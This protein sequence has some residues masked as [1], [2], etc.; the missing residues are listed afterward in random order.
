ML[1]DAFASEWTNSLDRWATDGGDAR[2][3]LDGAFCPGLH[4]SI[5]ACLRPE[6]SVAFLFESLPSCDDESRD[7]SPFVFS[8]EPDNLRLARQLER[9]N[10]WPMVHC[11]R[12]TEATASLAARLGDWCA[13]DAD[14]Q[15]LNL[16][17]P[18]TR[19]LSGICALLTDRQR[20]DM[21]GPARR[22]SYIGR[23]GRWADLDININCT[24]PGHVEAT[25]NRFGGPQLDSAQFAAM[26]D[27]GEADALMFVL[28]ERG[29]N[30]LGRHAQVY[31][32]VGRALELARQARLD[33]AST[34]EWCEA[35][36]QQP[37]WI[38]DGPASLKRWTTQQSRSANPTA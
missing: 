22:W 24:R 28:Q 13:V 3:M 38:S 11:I 35:C 36:V 34:L 7:V 32:V 8:H 15:R 1:I 18:D 5:R 2:L 31:G 29:T 21:F 23:D 9:C 14:G 10:G 4:R 20:H 33:S 37:S 19:R 16:R 17:F 12:T 25:S 26:V 27:D 6:A 30:W